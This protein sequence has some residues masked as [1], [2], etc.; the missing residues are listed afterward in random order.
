MRLVRQPK[1]SNQCGQASVA[2]LAGLSLRRAIDLVETSGKTTTRQLAG[3][4]RRAGLECSGKLRRGKPLGFGHY[5]AK[6][7]WFSCGN[8]RK[9]SHWIVLDRSLRGTT[10]LD[11]E[12]G[13]SGTL[14]GDG[15][16]SSYMKI[17]KR[18]VADVR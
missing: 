4:L 12:M 7:R 17:E 8:R 15:C 6:V 14:L 3:A 11:P 13:I 1:D 16:V 10:Y 5:L 9:M 2:M 18:G